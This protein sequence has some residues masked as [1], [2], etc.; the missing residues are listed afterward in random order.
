MIEKIDNFVFSNDDIILGDIDTEMV[1]LFSNDI[2]L[3]SIYLNNIN[4]VDD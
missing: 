2:S 1:T 4:I 3:N